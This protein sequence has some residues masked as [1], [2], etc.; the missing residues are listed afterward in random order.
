MWNAD[1][2]VNEA[3]TRARAVYGLPPVDTQ[4]ELIIVAQ[5]DAIDVL[6]DSFALEAEIISVQPESVAVFSEVAIMQPEILAAHTESA[7]PP[8]EA[9]TQTTTAPES[10]VI[11]DNAPLTPDTTHL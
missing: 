2:S 9:V 6:P 3:C 5:V 11:A 10:L 4:L 7:A 8:Q 1:G